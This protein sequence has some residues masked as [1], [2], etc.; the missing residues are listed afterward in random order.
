MLRTD[1]RYVPSDWTLLPV[2]HI[3]PPQR[4]GTILWLL[5]HMV[6]Y[7]IQHR[8]RLTATDDADFLKRARWKA[9]QKTRRRER[10][11]KYLVL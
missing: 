8:Q 9:Y 2:F 4:R 3:W 10:I 7:S 1:H 11:G 5:A 6:Y